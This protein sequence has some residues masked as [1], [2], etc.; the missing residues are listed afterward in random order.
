MKM[1]QVH[2]IT[3]SKLVEEKEIPLSRRD[4]ISGKALKQG[5]FGGSINSRLD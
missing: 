5:R 1:S 4:V 3:S 2:S